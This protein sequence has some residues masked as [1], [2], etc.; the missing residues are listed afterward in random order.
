MLGRSD[1]AWAAHGTGCTFSGEREAHYWIGE[2]ED[3]A[4]AVRLLDRLAWVDSARPDVR[5]LAAELV[6]G[7]ADELGAARR[8]HAAV[9]RFVTYVDESVETFRSP[10]ETLE[11]G[12]D[13]DDSARL[14]A[15]LARAAGVRAELVYLP[16]SFATDD[17][18]VTR[19]A[20]HWAEATIGARFGEDPYVAAKRLGTQRRDLS[21]IKVSATPP[22]PRDVIARAVL[23]EAW[24]DPSFPEATPYAVQAAQAWARIESFYGNPGGW[25]K[26]S[27]NL[28]HSNNWGAVQCTT[29]GPGCGMSTDK[30]PDGSSFAVGFKIYATPVDGARDF[31]R[32][33]YKHRPG[34]AAVAK[35]EGSALDFVTAMHESAYFG[36][37][38]PE[39]VKEYGS[40]ASRWSHVPRQ[41]KPYPSAEAERAGK[42]CDREVR[43]LAAA[44]LLANAA[45]LAE[46]NGEPLAV[47][48]TSRRR[49]ALAVAGGAVA[50]AGV[51]LGVQWWRRGWPWT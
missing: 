4:A 36:G 1:L 32:H 20:G 31:L 16:Q 15:A 24:D 22:S 3:N 10:E 21:G 27:P 11:L 28:E 38:C 25:K 17:H 33:L 8:I 49:V 40:D 42:A 51:G 18:V 46:A 48:S 5:A 19:L 39:A 45:A 30:N 47:R 14:C 37:F 12:G 35:R 44:G 23:L 34:V 43:E 9:Q 50:L 13:C 29:P 26:K 6:A 2:C 7:A 41:G